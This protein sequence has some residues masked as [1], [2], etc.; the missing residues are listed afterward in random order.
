MKQEICLLQE[1]MAARGIDVCLVPTSDPHQSEYGNPHFQA[2]RYLSGFTGSA[3]T[4]IVT[5]TEAAQ[6]ADGRYFLQAEQQLAGSGITLMR[7]NQ[8]GVPS[9]LEYVKRMLPDGGRIACDGRVISASFGKKLAR[10]AKEKG[11]K[12]CTDE[13]LVDAVWKDRPVLTSRPIWRLKECYAGVSAGKKIADVRAAMSRY[14]AEIHILSSLDDIAWL[15][16]LRGDDIACNPV[17]FSFLILSQEEAIL[18]AFPEAMSPE[19]GA[20]LEELGVT[21]RPY[22]DFYEE[23]ARLSRGRRVLADTEKTSWRLLTAL[24]GAAAVLD[25]PDPTAQS[26]AVK[27]ETEIRCLRESHRKDGAAMVNFIYWLKN[28][29][30]K[31]PLT[32]ISASDH[33]E[34]LRREQ[35]A[36]DLSF[37]T[38]AGYGPHGA[39][40]H[41]TATP[42]TD[43]PLEPS[44][45]LLVDSGGHYLEGTTDITRTIALGPVTEEEKTDFTLVLRGAIDLAMARFPKGATGATLDVLARM[46]LWERGLDYRHGTGHG[47][48]Y[49]LNVH[50]GPQQI[51]WQHRGRRPAAPI[52]PGMVTSDEPGYYPAG[53]H[54][55]RTENELLCVPF[56]ETEYGEFYAFEV[57]T[58]CPIER[59]AIVPKMLTEA[60]REWLNAY[61]RRVYEEIGPRVAPEVKGWLMEVT[62]EI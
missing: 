14:S 56:T 31:E 18:Y 54:G 62:E 47:I 61:H 3:G 13:D 8:P 10:I 57:L 2:P 20:Y 50:E 55:I 9:T 59:E 52:V 33:L 43:V 48:G 1:E 38:I 5:R 42:E 34:A 22:S 53:E 60:E 12:L 4:L 58:L 51:N 19:I 35:G 29:V 36:I 6:W 39:I 24:S 23:A 25:T 41:Y 44:G 40:I 26:K 45:L 46:P 37:D 16:N 17:F 7:L 30:G 49:L 32:E 11:G 27:N 15:L 28:T 21:V